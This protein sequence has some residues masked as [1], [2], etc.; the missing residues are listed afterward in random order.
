MLS[1][2]ASD[3]LASKPEP[4]YAVFFSVLWIY[5]HYC[6]YKGSW[7]YLYARSH[8]FYLKKIFPV[9]LSSFISSFLLFYCSI[10][11]VSKHALKSSKFKKTKILDHMLQ[12]SCLSISWFNSLKKLSILLPPLSHLPSSSKPLHS[13]YFHNTLKLVLKITQATKILLI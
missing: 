5:T 9:I 8:P 6:S 11:W 4:A 3:C 13:C 10:L 7:F 2:D 1:S 12:S